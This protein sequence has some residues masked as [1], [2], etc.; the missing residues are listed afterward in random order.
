MQPIED[1]GGL[2][3]A[4]NWRHLAHWYTVIV[5]D[6]IG[7]F[8]NFARQAVLQMINPKRHAEG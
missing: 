8:N 3:N 2:A 5:S 6:T 7:R 4:A 1:F